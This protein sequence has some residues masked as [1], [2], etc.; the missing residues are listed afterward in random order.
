[1]IRRANRTVKFDGTTRTTFAY[2]AGEQVANVERRHRRV[3]RIVYDPSGN[4]T[5]KRFPDAGTITTF[6]WDYEN[7]NTQVEL[8]SATNR[9]T[10]AYDPATIT[11]F[12]RRPPR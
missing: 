1:M 8:L 7:R 11:A 2:N 3:R 5:T 10:F 12:R 9:V 6:A 4:M